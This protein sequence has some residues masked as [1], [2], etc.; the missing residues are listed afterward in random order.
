MGYFPLDPVKFE[1]RGMAQALPQGLRIQK[2]TGPDPL[3]G[4]ALNTHP[5]TERQA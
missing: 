2:P 5:L 3:L 4:T 1:W